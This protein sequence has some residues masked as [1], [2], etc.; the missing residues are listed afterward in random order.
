MRLRSR[1]VPAGFGQ[2]A[3]RWIL[4]FLV[5]Y[6]F[7]HWYSL[8]GLT[9]ESPLAERIVMMMGP[10]P[11]TISLLIA[12]ALFVAGVETRR[13]RSSRLLLFSLGA[14]LLAA[15][16]PSVTVS[17]MPTVPEEPWEPTSVSSPELD[18]GRMLLPLT[19]AVFTPLAAVAG[20]HVGHV[21]RWWSP[22][23]RE[24][25]RRFACLALA[26]SFWL[27]LWVSVTLVLSTGL[28]AVWILASLI[29][30]SLLVGTVVARRK[31]EVSVVGSWQE[32]AT[33]STSV[34]QALDRIVSSVARDQDPALLRADAGS[35]TGLIGETTDLLVGIRRIVSPGARVTESQVREIVAALASRSPVAASRH[36]HSW[37]LRIGAGG[38]G[39]FCAQW[40]CIAAG[41][42]VSS[43]LTGVP[44]SPSTAVVVAFLASGATML[45]VRR[46]TA[47]SEPAR[48]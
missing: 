2:L 38:L 40:T 6:A 42:L 44:P 15:V 45:F 39:E 12:P 14:Y 11:V 48:I 25:A 18:L 24:S 30:P 4:G 29:P 47:P 28:P 17:L 35:R 16:G 41:L 19:I 9:G 36:R 27:P 37:G 3:G 43:P 26:A 7:Y 22:G 5:I 10:F 34:H 1:A 13:S 46:Y 32:T 21:T 8:A 23:R 20:V 33:P 31:G